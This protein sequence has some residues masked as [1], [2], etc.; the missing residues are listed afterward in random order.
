MR[1]TTRLIIRSLRARGGVKMR[2]DLAQ[3]TSF[4]LAFDNLISTIER[5]DIH[6]DE[7]LKKQLTDAPSALPYLQQ[8]D[9]VPV[10]VLF[11][12]ASWWKDNESLQFIEA[13]FLA[14]L[15]QS[16]LVLKDAC[17]KEE[18]LTTAINS[19][20]STCIESLKK[21][22]ENIAEEMLWQLQLALT[23][24][25]DFTKTYPDHNMHPFHYFHDYIKK[26]GNEN[27]KNDCNALNWVQSRWYIYD[28]KSK[29]WHTNPDLIPNALIP[30]KKPMFPQLFVGTDVRYET[31]CDIVPYVSMKL[32]QGYLN[33]LTFDHY[34]LNSL[35]VLQRRLLNICTE[36]DRIASYQLR[37]RPIGNA[38]AKKVSEAYHKELYETEVGIIKKQYE[39]MDYLLKKQEHELL[40]TEKSQTIIQTVQALFQRAIYLRN[41]QHRYNHPTPTAGNATVNVSPVDVFIWV[42]NHFPIKR[43]IEYSTVTQTPSYCIPTQDTQ[44]ALTKMFAVY[45]PTTLTESEKDALNFL[46]KV[47]MAN[48]WHDDNGPALSGKELLDQAMVLNNDK[49]GDILNPLI[50]RFIVPSILVNNA[51]ITLLESCQQMLHAYLTPET[52]TQ[53][54]ACVVSIKNTLQLNKEILKSALLAKV[55]DSSWRGINSDTTRTTI[56]VGHDAVS[57]DEFSQCVRSTLAPDDFKPIANQ[58]LENYSGDDEDVWPVFSIFPRDE[59][60]KYALKRLEYLLDKENGYQNPSYETLFESRCL[61]DLRNCIKT[62]DQCQRLLHEFL[63]AHKKKIDVDIDTVNSLDNINRIFYLFGDEQLFD[64]WKNHLA[65]VLSIFVKT[66]GLN[67][68]ETA[69]I[70]TPLIQYLKDHLGIFWENEYKDLA[71]IINIM[72]FSHW[73]AEKHELMR[74]VYE[75]NFD[76]HE[77]TLFLS[78]YYNRLLKVILLQNTNEQLLTFLPSLHDTAACRALIQAPNLFTDFKRAASAI[79]Q[80][81]L[82]GYNAL[83]VIRALKKVVDVFQHNDIP[84]NISI[85]AVTELYQDYSKARDVVQTQKEIENKASKIMQKIIKDGINNATSEEIQ[86]LVRENT[87][88]NKEILLII[89]TVIPSLVFIGKRITSEMAKNLLQLMAIHPVIDISNPVNTL[90]ILLNQPHVETVDQLMQ[91]TSGISQASVIALFKKNPADAVSQLEALRK[92]SEKKRNYPNETMKRAEES[93]EKIKENIIDLKKMRRNLIDEI[94]LLDFA[95]AISNFQ[96]LLSVQRSRQYENGEGHTVLRDLL[97]SKF[98]PRQNKQITIGIHEKTFELSLNSTGSTNTPLLKQT[99]ALLNVLGD[100][101]DLIEYVEYWTEAAGYMS[102]LYNVVNR[103]EFRDVSERLETMETLQLFEAMKSREC[104]KNNRFLNQYAFYIDPQERWITTNNNNVPLILLAVQKALDLFSQSNIETMSDCVKIKHPDWTTIVTLISNQCNTSM[105]VAQESII[106]EMFGGLLSKLPNDLIPQIRQMMSSYVVVSTQEITS[107]SLS[108]KTLPD[109]GI[110]ENIAHNGINN[111]GAAIPVPTEEALPLSSAADNIVPQQSTLPSIPVNGLGTIEIREE[112]LGTC[113]SSFNQLLAHADKLMAQ[114]EHQ[115][116]A[117]NFYG[118]GYRKGESIKKYLM[119]VIN[120]LSDPNWYNNPNPLETIINQEYKIRYIYQSKNIA[121]RVPQVEEDI[122]AKRRRDYHYLLPGSWKNNTSTKTNELLND[123]QEAIRTMLEEK[124]QP[125][126]LSQENHGAA[127]VASHQQH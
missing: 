59:A 3:S 68:P 41:I 92:E 63:L 80:K 70:I 115:K 81:K 10:G 126:A 72:D 82:T 67:L 114:G 26:Y 65:S 96:T 91:P 88:S 51:G 127:S 118:Q 79:S 95:K 102:R 30:E 122:R 8:R 103:K 42:L 2:T 6:L 77:K 85:D 120:T 113:F 43:S 116:Q 97:T 94:K 23:R 39:I 89:I 14:P 98:S 16:L 55:T 47:M 34:S 100:M 48:Y 90:L 73:N 99:I 4:N 58:Y 84:S 45:L 108:E 18:L 38:E 7:E 104:I 71:N 29:R 117:F 119:K 107:P 9:V 21:E 28:E 27:T 17:E 52:K 86:T 83:I 93:I 53:M 25:L 40:L 106:T 32:T 37:L 124:R 24:D 60:I 22:R 76:E 56:V 110:D 69:Q 74:I 123:F 112:T 78:L 49:V 20:I 54:A 44:T 105:K 111:N 13:K 1:L 125:S 5:A 66:I 50:Q 62:S 35:D 46:L 31:F 57:F 36:R 19:V 15:E 33:Q 64:T 75:N 11:N 12:E 101:N 121:A 87:L 61:S 109:H